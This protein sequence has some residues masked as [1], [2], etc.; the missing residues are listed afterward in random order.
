MATVV[1]ILAAGYASLLRVNAAQTAR[2]AQRG[3]AAA[4]GEARVAAPVAPDSAGLSSR[5]QPARGS[6]LDVLA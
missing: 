6:A 5:G 2:E 3:P 1:P 4:P